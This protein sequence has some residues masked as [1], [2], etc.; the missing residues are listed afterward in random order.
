L[1]MRGFS[2]KE[3]EEEPFKTWEDAAFA[4]AKGI[5]EI[6]RRTRN[7]RC[8]KLHPMLVLCAAGVYP[9]PDAMFLAKDVLELLLYSGYVSY[10]R[11][12]KCSRSEDNLWVSICLFRVSQSPPYFKPEK[13]LRLL[14][15]A[16]EN[17]P[18]E[19]VKHVFELIV[20][21]ENEIRES[22]RRIFGEPDVYVDVTDEEEASDDQTGNSSEG[23]EEEG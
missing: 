4:V 13:A 11:R 12:D 19:A 22:E 15:L 10:V 18:E 14:N 23:E 8:I 17:S 20:N 21:E 16:R 9:T 1:H 7:R 5:V 3:N 2:P 6:A